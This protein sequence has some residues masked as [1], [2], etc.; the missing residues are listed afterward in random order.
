MEIVETGRDVIRQQK[1]VSRAKV[2]ASK[3]T[4]VMTG[5]FV[6]LVP[7]DVL[8]EKTGAAAIVTA[9]IGRSVRRPII[10]KPKQ[11]IV[12]MIVIALLVKP[13]MNL[14]TNVNN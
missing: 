4:S 2:T 5:N 8:W 11:D 14:C 1:N 12:T 9:V 7:T 3:T 13:A 6:Q 10:A